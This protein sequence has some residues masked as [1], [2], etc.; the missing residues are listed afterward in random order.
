MNMEKMNMI[1]IMRIPSAFLLYLMIFFLGAQF[2]IGIAIGVMANLGL[3]TGMFSTLWFAIA[4]QLI[5]II[6]PLLIWLRVKRDRFRVKTQ[7][8][9]GVNIVFIFVVSILVQPA[10]MLIS[11]FFSQF[12]VNDAAEALNHFSQQP[13]WLMMLAFAVT[14]AI[15]EELVFRGYIQSHQRM[16]NFTRV[17]LM[18]GF[19]FGLMHFSPHQF[20]YTVP[21]GIMFAYIVYYTRSIWAGIISH[22]IINGS[23]VT[24][25]HV[26]M[27]G[28]DGGELPEVSLTLSQELYAIFAET[29]PER[30][31]ALYD[32]AYG[33]SHHFFLLVVMSVLT[34]ITLPIAV[35]VFLK[36][37]MYNLHR[38]RTLDFAEM[39][40]LD[41]FISK[42]YGSH[43]KL[44]ADS[45]EDIDA[46]IKKTPPS[47]DYIGY[48]Y[49]TTFSFEKEVSRLPVFVRKINWY[50]VSA[51]ALYLAVIVLVL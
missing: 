45:P 12:F 17:A 10:M 20:F 16:K 37:R 5:C 46:W 11:A 40:E 7:P 42:H 48:N 33:M 2:L 44:W 9:G 27:R 43:N 22:F 14:P 35:I 47:G 30:A 19:F 3:Y 23:Q 51:I 21:L 25:S 26:I 39:R 38:N 32:L 4:M 34:A 6:L 13:W 15:V 1:K 8:L 24:L 18:N 28:L 49:R 36:M 41:I 31:Q 29:D 50:L